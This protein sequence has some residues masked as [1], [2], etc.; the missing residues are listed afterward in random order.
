WQVFARHVYSAREEQAIDTFAG[1]E[2]EACCWKLRVFGGR[3]VS[4]RTGEQD[5]SVSIQLELKGLSSVGSG[6]EAFPGRGIRGYSR[7]IG[8]EP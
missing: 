7:R 4:N 8:F 2:Y 1:L 3:Y 6:G 5:T